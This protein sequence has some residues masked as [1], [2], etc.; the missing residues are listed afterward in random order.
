[1]FDQILDGER[2]D[3]VMCASTYSGKGVEDELSNGIIC[4]HAYSVLAAYDLNTP[5]GRVK[6]V[7]L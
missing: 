4:G 6:L 1:M 2:K 3:Y 5:R 7:K